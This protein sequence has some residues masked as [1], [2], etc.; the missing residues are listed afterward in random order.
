MLNGL[1]EEFI[2]RGGLGWKMKILEAREEFNKLIVGTG[3]VGRT[4]I[5][6]DDSLRK[7]FVNNL[8]GYAG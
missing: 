6:E 4:L 5:R 8:L 1:V 2:E 7:V 3:N